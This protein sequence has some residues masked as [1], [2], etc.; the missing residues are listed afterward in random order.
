MSRIKLLQSAEIK[1]FDTPPA[2]T[3]QR[4]AHFFTVPAELQSE[5]DSL[6]QP[7]TRLGFLLQ[8]GYFRSEGRFYETK[9]FR[10]E[11]IEYL[12]QPYQIHVNRFVLADFY[13][14]QSKEQHRVKILRQLAWSSFEEC[15][16]EFEHH[17]TL[18][19]ERQLLPRKILREIKAYLFRQRIEGPA[20]DT[21]LKVITLALLEASKQMNQLLETHLTNQHCQILDTFLEK[22][23]SPHR[24][25]I[26]HFKHINQ[27]LQPKAIKA[28]LEQFILLMLKLENLKELIGKLQLSD[29]TIDYHA[30]WSS[31]AEV[32][33]IEQHAQKYLFLLCF[34]IRQVRLRQDFFIDIILQTVKAAGNSTKRL[35]KE[36]YFLDQ[37]QRQKATQLLVV[38]RANYRDQIEA[39]KNIMRSQVSDREKVSAIE[40][41]LEEDIDL[42]A[43]REA[44]VQ[45][46]ASELSRDEQEVFYRLWEKRSTWLTNRI[47]QVGLN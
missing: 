6:R 5:F 42:P 36:D 32:D 43:E 40:S 2:F 29:A 13:S 41:L 3:T 25:D 16:P 11:D 14:A 27:S 39:V 31:I 7:Y 17:V 33:K 30:Y 21:Y 9:D 26:V 47:G 46:L 8:M 28:S 1:L 34:L 38:S 24:A 15:R 12:G 18:L 19:V 23:I 45:T 4:Q 37:R 35:Q 22:T 20:Y 10:K 44:Q